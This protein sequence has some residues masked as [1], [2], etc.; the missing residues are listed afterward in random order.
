[1]GRGVKGADRLRIKQGKGLRAGE[2]A[3]TGVFQFPQNVHPEDAF[4]SGLSHDENNRVRDDFLANCDVNNEVATIWYTLCIR[5]HHPEPGRLGTQGEVIPVL[6][7][8][9][10]AY[11]CHLRTSVDQRQGFFSLYP[12]TPPHH[13]PCRVPDY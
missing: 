1:M 4:L 9:S 6:V 5:R 7:K 12:H 3:K 13:L 8:V 10:L 2:R 11:R